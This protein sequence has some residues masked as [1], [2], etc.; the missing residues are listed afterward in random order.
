MT[1][2][3]S[4]MMPRVIAA[5]AVA[6]ATGLGGCASSDEFKLERRVVVDGLEP[7]G[8]TLAGLEAVDLSATG[9]TWVNRS[10]L[11]DVAVRAV[12]ATVLAVDGDN[13]AARASGALAL[14]P[15]GA[16]ADGSADVPLGAFTD[17]PL[18]PGETVS[19]PT[20]AAAG[21]VL[22]RALAGSGRVALV[23]QGQADRRPVGFAL[24][25]ALDVRT[26]YTP[27]GRL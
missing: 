2:T 24:K 27:L 5:L 4:Y 19:L 13:K 3:F 11:R 8:T 26:S 20:S 9:D 15:E 22:E 6:L 21:E 10:H 14:R 18:R 7:G 25:V 1:T 16:P 17:M 23:V 12:Q